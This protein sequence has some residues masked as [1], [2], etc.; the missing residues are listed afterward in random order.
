MSGAG[1]GGEPDQ[2]L[3]AAIGSVT[4][5]DAFTILL[6]DH[7]EQTARRVY[8][9][10]PEAFAASGTKSMTGTVWAEHLTA[11]REPLVSSGAETIRTTFP[12]HAQILPLGITAVVNY[13]VVEGGICTGCV[14][15]LYLTSEP[16]TEPRKHAG[17]VSVI[18]L[19]IAQ[20]CSTGQ[21]WG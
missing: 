14:N 17:V 9:S 4:G 19:S 12:D 18:G 16:A 6:F 15:C 7:E 1:I 21:A 20:E 3:V 13:P 2:G 8:S 5:C 10:R 11:T